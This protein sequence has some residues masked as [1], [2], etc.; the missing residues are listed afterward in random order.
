MH[1]CKCRLTKQGR[2]VCKRNLELGLIG[3]VRSVMG[4]VF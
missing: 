3:G 1:G 2:I 4:D